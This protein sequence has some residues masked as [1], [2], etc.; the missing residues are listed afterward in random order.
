MP[1]RRQEGFKNNK[2]NYP[3]GIPDYLI[4]G[5]AKPHR[6][7][8]AQLSRN[9]ELSR[10]EKMSDSELEKLG[11][12]GLAPEVLKIE[13]SNYDAI[14][15]Q[16]VTIDDIAVGIA[17]QT[18]EI[19]I[20]RG[21]SEEQVSDIILS[22]YD[23]GGPVSE[24]GNIPEIGQIWDQIIE[25]AEKSQTTSHLAPILKVK[26]KDKYKAIGYQRF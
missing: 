25:A 14:I 10:L 8:P 23:P 4:Y 3:Q 7:W 18:M 26:V 12:L 11:L 2:V 24:H 5:V 9:L 17:I 22:G 13:W 1:S 19:L 6:Y 16:A 15:E 20:E 21:V